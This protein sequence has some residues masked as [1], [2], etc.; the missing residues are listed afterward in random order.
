LK[1]KKKPKGAEAEPTEFP[2]EGVE[3]PEF[4]VDDLFI[5]SLLLFCCCFC[6]CSDSSKAA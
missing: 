6:N 5:E 4:C 1:N 2:N 3:V